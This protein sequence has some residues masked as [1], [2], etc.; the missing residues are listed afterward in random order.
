MPVLDPRPN[1]LEGSTLSGHAYMITAFENT[2]VL[3]R[4]M[5][6]LDDE[7]NHLYLHIDKKA[8]DF[9]FDHFATTCEQAQ[10]TFVPRVK[11]S[12][13]D[14]SQVESVF[15]LLRHATPGRHR[16]YHLL[17]GADMPLKSQDHIHDF[18]R[19]HDGTEFVGFAPWFEPE[20]VR[21][22][23]PGTRYLRAG[24]AWVRR[25]AWG[26]ERRSARWQRRAGYDRTTQFPVTFRKGSDWY[27]IT[28]ELAVHLLS[29]EHTLR[30]MLRW[31]FIPT[32]FYVQTIVWNSEFR[33]RIH[34]DGDQ[35]ASSVRYIDWSELSEGE[36]SPHVFRTADF[37]RLVESERLFARKFDAAVDR[38]VIDMIY[39]HVDSCP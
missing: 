11:V 2:Y 12:W 36:F 35:F 39:D 13:G 10:V 25:V 19:E 33:H 15:S 29:Q 6:L 3:D 30:R 26:A 4:L 37:P 38:A 27:S 34:D 17:S 20:W 22:V 8:K 16:Y 23:H 31:A 28:H 14:Y 1:P 5:H 7:R 9:D 24:R 32:E 18:F 21:F